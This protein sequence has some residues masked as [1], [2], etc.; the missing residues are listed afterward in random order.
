MDLSLRSRF[1]AS[2][3]PQTRGHALA[4]G[5]RSE[6]IEKSIIF[7]APVFTVYYYFQ[8]TEK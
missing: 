8:Y 5:R 3:L 1:S 7:S 4:G 2:P 6:I